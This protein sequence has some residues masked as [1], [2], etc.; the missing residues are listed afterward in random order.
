MIR[1]FPIDLPTFT[2][3]QVSGF[4]YESDDPA[5]LGEDMLEIRMPQGL[6]LDVGWYPEGA[7]DGSYRFTARRGAKEIVRRD[8]FP[9]ARDVAEY[10][11][12]FLDGLSHNP[13]TYPGEAEGSIVPH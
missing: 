9:Q 13:V 2:A 5:D 1:K 12:G 10:L 3:E 11:K 6:T 7:L 4:L 8:G